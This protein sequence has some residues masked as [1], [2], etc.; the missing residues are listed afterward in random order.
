MRGPACVLLPVLCSSLQAQQRSEPLAEFSYATTV[1]TGMGVTVVTPC[2]SHLLLTGSAGYAG[3]TRLAAQVSMNGDTLI[4]SIVQ[5]RTD[6]AGLPSWTPVRWQLIIWALPPATAWVR[7]FVEGRTRPAL[8]EAL[9]RG[10]PPPND[11]RRCS[12]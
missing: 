7:V 6:S 3:G 2:R 8:D 10:P 5:V 9:P 11:P 4:A 12:A 1:D